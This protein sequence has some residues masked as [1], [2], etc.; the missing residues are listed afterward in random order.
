MGGRV[1]VRNLENV[2]K[3]MRDLVPQ[4]MKELKSSMNFAG[5]TLQH[6]V[7]EKAKLTDHSLKQLAEMGH[8]YAWKTGDAVKIGDRTMKAASTDTAPHS[9][10]FVHKQSGNLYDN[11]EKV[12]HLEENK[13][14][15]AVGVNKEKVPYIGYLIDG[16]SKM[17]PRDFLGHAWLEV[18][19]TVLNIIKSGLRPKRGSRNGKTGRAGGG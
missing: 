11:I 10:E 4:T 14:L 3:N 1:T 5:N 6:A 19:E 9:D 8:P 17:R 12:V 15:V 2:I 7:Q 13:A 16:T 18:R